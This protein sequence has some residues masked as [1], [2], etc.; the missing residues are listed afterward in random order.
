MKKWLAVLYLVGGHEMEKQNLSERFC[1]ELL[2]LLDEAFEHT[3][4][5]FLDKGASLL[6]T[7]E[8]IPASEASQPV[9]IG[10]SS[11]AAQV[12]HIR[13]YLEVLESD[14]RGKDFGEVDW[15]KSWQVKEVTPEEWESLKARLRQTYQSVVSAIKGIDHWGCE[16]D[17]G[18]PMAILA[19]TAYHLGAIRQLLS[20]AD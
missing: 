5:F 4:G 9:S 13:Y 7:V 17:I 18:A 11:I 15:Q 10:G 20:K 2:G 8:N 14:I 1:K 16:N 3:H 19:H 12:D 6:E